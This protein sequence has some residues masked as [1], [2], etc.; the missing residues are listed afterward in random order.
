MKHNTPSSYVNDLSRRVRSLET[1]EIPIAGSS[2]GTALAAY[3]MLPQLRLFV[4]FSST[5]E[6]GNAYDL[7][8]QGR[9]LAN[10][11]SAT[12]GVVN[13]SAYAAVDG[14]T[15]YFNRGDE[16]GLDI[17]GALTIGGWFYA[18]ALVAA[19]AYTLI[20][21][22]GA[23][24]ARGYTIYIGNGASSVLN[25]QISSDG[26]ATTTV[27]SAYD[28]AA[29]EWRYIAMRYTPSTELA[30]FDTPSGVLT[31]TVNTTAIPAAMVNNAN[32]LTIGARSDTSFKFNGRFALCYL[33]AAALSDATIEALYQQ[34]LG[35][36]A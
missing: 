32:Q 4:P 17:T 16:A 33:C 35:L 13:S 36:F 7:S 12:F 9:T 8:G 14:A 10:T 31:K 11:G 29:T 6:S 20:A 28:V 30:L 22:S 24:G 21:K 26:T 5:D 34:T 19:S 1:M 27:T 15:Q 2:A 25:G 3:Q 18:S 23:A